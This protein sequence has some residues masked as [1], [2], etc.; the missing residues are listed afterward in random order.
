MISIT[1]HL[2]NRFLCITFHVSGNRVRIFEGFFTKIT[3]NKLKSFS[4]ICSN[5]LFTTKYFAAEKLLVKLFSLKSDFLFSQSI[6]YMEVLSNQIFTIASTFSHFF[7]LKTHPKYIWGNSD[8]SQWLQVVES[9]MAHLDLKDNKY[10]V[11]NL[12]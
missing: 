1:V 8:I 10:Q 7:Q 9:A 12:C 4:P 2:I 6:K 11:T 3:Q 5:W